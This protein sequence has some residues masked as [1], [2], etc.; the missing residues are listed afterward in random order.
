MCE[1]VNVL[2]DYLKSSDIKTILAFL[3]LSLYIINFLYEKIYCNYLIYN[4]YK[5]NNIIIISKN[6][7]FKYLIFDI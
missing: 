4:C 3:I 5:D 7:I 2:C 6:S 1:F